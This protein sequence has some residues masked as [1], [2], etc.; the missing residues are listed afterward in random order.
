[1]Q[2]ITNLSQPSTCEQPQVIV[3]AFDQPLH[4]A[5]QQTGVG[6]IISSTAEKSIR[7]VRLTKEI[8]IVCNYSLSIN[9]Y[10]V[11]ELL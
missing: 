6:Y 7:V 9:V 8:K 10:A 2:T 5:A 3:H 1:M 4:F 11:N